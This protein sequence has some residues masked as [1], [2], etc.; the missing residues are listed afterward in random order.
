MHLNPVQLGSCAKDV[1]AF[2]TSGER[3]IQVQLLSQQYSTEASLQRDD[4]STIDT[5]SGQR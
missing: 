3:L 5:R 2:R 4:N 1:A